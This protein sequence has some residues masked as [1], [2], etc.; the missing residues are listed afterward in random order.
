MRDA[1]LTMLLAQYNKCLVLRIMKIFA[2][3]AEMDYIMT[4][5]TNISYWYANKYDRMIERNECTISFT[6][7]YRLLK[8][9]WLTGQRS[10]TLIIPR[11]FATEYGLDKPVNVIVEGTPEGILIR[12]LE[13]FLFHF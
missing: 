12:K 7:N 10:C 2:H 5:L 13:L 4:C 8:R 3:Y 6:P 11:E 1:E 9:T